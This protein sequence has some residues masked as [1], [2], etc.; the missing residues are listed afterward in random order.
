ML[1]E[2]PC[3]A[4]LLADVV[5]K[6]LATRKQSVALP[7]AALLLLCISG[8]HVA[9]PHAPSQVAAHAERHAPALAACLSYSSIARSGIIARR[10]CLD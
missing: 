5:P 10:Q 6:A 9:R 8:A 7:A 4:T 3:T 2:L 1:D